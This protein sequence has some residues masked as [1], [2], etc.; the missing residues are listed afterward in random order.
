TADSTRFFEI[1][2]AESTAGS[3]GE[4]PVVFLF[5]RNP[6]KY[7]ARN[8][9]PRPARPPPGRGE[10]PEKEIG[11]DWGAPLREASGASGEYA[12]GKFAEGRLLRPTVSGPHPPV[13][14]PVFPPHQRR[15]RRLFDKGR[16]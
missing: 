3:F 7:P 16:R 15:S 1:W 4:K 12:S 5:P 6:A 9:R 14:P 11:R 2:W 10:N 8:R 13:R